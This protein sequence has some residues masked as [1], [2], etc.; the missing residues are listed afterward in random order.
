MQPTAVVHKHLEASAHE[1]EI[2]AF[3]QKL[4]KFVTCHFETELSLKKWKSW[5][6]RRVN[7]DSLQIAFHIARLPRG[8]RNAHRF[9]DAVPRCY[10]FLPLALQQQSTSFLV[11]LEFKKQNVAGFESGTENIHQITS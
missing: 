11:N 3:I 10:A 7:E 4:R 1:A 9:V 5:S 6:W 2:V 8:V